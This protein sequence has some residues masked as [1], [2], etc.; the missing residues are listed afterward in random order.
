MLIKRF[1]EIL[2]FHDDDFLNS[3]YCVMAV[4]NRFVVAS[5]VTDPLKTI[6]NKSDKWLKNHVE[7]RNDEAWLNFLSSKKLNAPTVQECLDSSGKTNLVKMFMDIFEKA[8]G[9]GDVDYVKLKNYLNGVIP[10]PRPLSAFLITERDVISPEVLQERKRI[11]KKF[12][13]HGQSVEDVA[14]NVELSVQEVQTIY[15]NINE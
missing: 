1:F 11:A 14:A 12:L 13:K 3:N 5:D 9:V 6:F 8:H 10:F 15:D 2:H 7:L 4:D